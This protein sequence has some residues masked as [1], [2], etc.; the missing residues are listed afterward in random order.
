MAGAHR[1]RGE[2]VRPPGRREDWHL[3]NAQREVS[4]GTGSPQ[5]RGFL[6]PCAHVVGDGIWS[7]SFVREAIAH[8]QL[9]RGQH[10]QG[11]LMYA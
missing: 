5:A 7:V 2:H 6:R 10:P 1:P 4:C 8:V 9:V 3:R 11:R